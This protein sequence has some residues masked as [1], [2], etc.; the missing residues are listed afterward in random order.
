M[1]WRT[2]DEN[3]RW[4]TTKRNNGPNFQYAKFTVNE[5]VHTDRRNL[6]GIREKSDCGKSSNCWFSFASKSSPSSFVSVC[7]AFVHTV[8]WVRDKSFKIL[9]ERWFRNQK[10]TNVKFSWIKDIY[11]SLVWRME[12]SQ[13]SLWGFYCRKPRRRKSQPT[14]NTCPAWR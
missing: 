1:R 5:L 11:F 7:T 8:T 10:I 9:F 13:T 12:I 3:M 4:I 2:R 14:E 6:S